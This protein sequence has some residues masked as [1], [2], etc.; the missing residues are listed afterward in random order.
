MASVADYLK[1]REVERARAAVF[2]KN[3]LPTMNAA[4]IKL[5]CMEHEGYETPSLNEKLYLHFRGY[6]KIEN[7]EEYPN[8][9]TL[10]LESNGLRKIENIEHLKQ[11]RC[12]Y[13]HQNVIE[14][15]SGLDTLS[16]LRT[17]NLSQNKIAKIS[18]LKGLE[19]L[20]TLNLGKNCLTNA[21]DLEG[22]LECP[23]ITNLDLSSNNIDDV[24]IVEKVLKKMPKLSALYL[25][26]NP[27]VRKIKHYR[28]TMLSTMPQLA[29]LD[30]RPVFELERVA[31]KAWKEGGIE[32]EREAR[33]Q[34]QASS[35]VK[36]AALE[37]LLWF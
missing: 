16:E 12:L 36:L 28:K 29:Y 3:G 31:V 32:A 13:L 14:E 18:N 15:M 2:D 6:R 26:G 37:E 9:K 8:V 4:A 19:K 24:E 30:E 20:S 1:K 21:E 35:K 27:C 25:K 33:K 10:F 22:L 5:S 34:F 23:S 17:L 11:L 7:L